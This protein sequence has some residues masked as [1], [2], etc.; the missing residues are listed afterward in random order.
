MTIAPAHLFLTLASLV[1]IN[2]SSP[3]GCSPDLPDCVNRTPARHLL[4][5]C[6]VR[7]MGKRAP[8][9]TVLANGV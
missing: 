8:A 7:V 1:A 6:N 4:L 5:S 9:T 2:S 3:E